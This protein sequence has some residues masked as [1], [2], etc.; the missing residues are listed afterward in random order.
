M[1]ANT[2]TVNQNDVSQVPLGASVQMV[3]NQ[4]ATT[5]EW[6]ILSVPVDAPQPTLTV[7]TTTQQDDT[8]TFV[9]ARE[10][11]YLLKLTVDFGLSTQFI[12]TL[13]VSV[14]EAET[15]DRL[16]A[17]GETLENADWAHSAVDRVLRRVTR[18]SDNGT[19]FGVVP[20]DLE[21]GSVVYAYS[22]T[23][24]GDDNRVVPFFLQAFP[25]SLFNMAYVS[26]FLGVYESASGVG[27]R[28]RHTG[29]VRGVVDSS[30]PARQTKVYL[31]NDG[32]PSLTAGTI[33]RII[34]YVVGSTSTTFDFMLATSTAQRPA[35]SGNAYDVMSFHNGF[36][37]AGQIIMD[38][39]AVRAFTLSDVM[40][41]HKMYALTNAQQEA[42]F[43]LTRNGNVILI[44]T[45]AASSGIPTFSRPSGNPSLTIN[46]ND[47]VRLTGPAVADVGLSFLR[48]SFK[49]ATV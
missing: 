25:T 13:A 18:H 8:A 26:G 7:S 2:V 32:K 11:S 3:H 44:M 36:V 27:A 12:G 20:P 6:M 14:R 22:T 45:F 43:T 5:R 23:T 19:V 15:G 37:G 29:L 21:L 28:I 31:G 49:G 10:G 34:G 16:P 35:S 9:A 40:S 24:I 46:A 1:S 42:V 41:E 4:S 38:F 39:K 47:L 48:W 30:Q 17:V 33:E